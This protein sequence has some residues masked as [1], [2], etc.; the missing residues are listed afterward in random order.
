MNPITL[1]IS[2]G[3]KK[4]FAG[5]GQLAGGST[6][7]AISVTQGA[8]YLSADATANAPGAFG[9]TIDATKLSP[10]TY[11]GMLLVQ[12]TGNACIPVPVQVIVTVNPGSGALNFTPAGE[13]LSMTSGVATPQTIGASLE[14]DGSSATGFTISSDQV[15]LTAVPA[16]G[17]LSPGQKTTVTISTSAANLTPG[18]YTGHIVAQ[19]TGTAGTFTVSLNV[20]G[21]NVT[22]T[23]N[24]LTLTLPSG[25]KQT[26]P[27]ALQLSG[28]AASVAI[29]VTQGGP[30]LTAD[31]VSQSPGAFAV[32]FDAT[33]LPAGTYSGALSLHCVP[34]CV[35]ITVAVSIVV[36]QGASNLSFGL[37]SATLSGNAGSATPPTTTTTLVNAGTGAGTFALNTDQSWLSVN[38]SSG[39]LAS[40]AST[41][42]TVSAASQYLAPGSYTGHVTA[43][44]AVFTVNFTVAGVAL[45]ASPSPANFNMAAGTE[46][47]VWHR[48][49]FGRRRS[50]ERRRDQRQRLVERGCHGASAGCLQPHDRRDKLEAG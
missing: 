19:G 34:G 2:S 28:D 25:N 17:N 40:G 47:V 50:G 21:A 38:P 39:T 37:P 3:S 24:P 18:S 13:T 23:P 27:G 7:V 44:S 42:I 8:N 14:N 32:T 15:W 20:T 33:K 4:T 46:A 1:S 45:F 48:T 6:N 5:V 35:P 11:A 36:T 31:S 12:C 22:V 29:G 26:F 43:G 10:A 16:S 9:V 41:K 49:G 30:Y